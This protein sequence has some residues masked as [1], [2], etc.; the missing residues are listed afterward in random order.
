MHSHPLSP[1]SNTLIF[2]SFRETEKQFF[3]RCHELSWGRFTMES[4]STSVRFLIHLT[5]Y[6]FFDLNMYFGFHQLSSAIEL[7]YHSPYLKKSVSKKSVSLHE[8]FYILIQHLI[9]QKFRLMSIHKCDLKYH[10]SSFP[11]L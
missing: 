8:L 9:F 1:S 2:H 11:S 5:H 4:D 10:L 3:P 7:L 6:N